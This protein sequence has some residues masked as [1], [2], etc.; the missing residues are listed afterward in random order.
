MLTRISL[1]VM[2]VLISTT[3]ATAQNQSGSATQTVSLVL[4]PI[5]QIS[6]VTA[7]N[8]QIG[9]NTTDQYANGVNSGNQQFKIQSNK[10][11]MISVKADAAN[12]AYSGSANPAPQMPVQNILYLALAD[13]NTGGAV[14]NSFGSY[15][16]LSSTPQDML[17]QC[18]NG[19]DK[20]FAVNYKA[21]PGNAYPA[22]TYTVG[23]VYTA[24]QP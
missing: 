14:A 10:D 7:S 5:I 21:K 15:T 8:V 20:T 3:F 13:N 1:A 19:S 22:G 6:A 4:A 9:F 12:F 23:I 16:S 2:A 24:T 17:V 18:R 11:F